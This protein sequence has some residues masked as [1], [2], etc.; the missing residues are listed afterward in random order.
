MLT[1]RPRPNTGRVPLFSMYS[2][3]SEEVFAVMVGKTVGLFYQD[4]TG[5]PVDGNLIE[6]PI[7]IDD[8]Q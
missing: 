6:F 5:S 8:E 3:E 1:L 4:M 7:S 2:S